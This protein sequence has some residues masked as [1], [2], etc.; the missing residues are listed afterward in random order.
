MAWLGTHKDEVNVGKGSV[1]LSVAL[2]L[3]NIP[4]TRV[5]NFCATGTEAFRAPPMRLPRA[6]ATSRS[7]SAWRS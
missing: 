3:N 2:R 6:R 7:R 5:E 4:V 1:P